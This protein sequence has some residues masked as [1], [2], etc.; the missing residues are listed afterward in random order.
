MQ[1]KLDDGSLERNNNCK[2]RTKLTEV[3][4]CGNQIASPGVHIRNLCLKWL[5]DGSGVNPGLYA[6]ELM[7]NCSEVVREGELFEPLGVLVEAHGRTD[8]QGSCTVTVA[9]LAGTVSS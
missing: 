8:L 2:Q 9:N 1:R 3:L 4:C 7:W 6:Q 5:F